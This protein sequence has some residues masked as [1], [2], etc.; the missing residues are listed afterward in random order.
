M[1]M[2]IKMNSTSKMK[3][4]P[5]PSLHNL[6]CPCFLSILNACAAL[7]RA[8][9]GFNIIFYQPTHLAPGFI[10]ILNASCALMRVRVDNEVGFV[11]D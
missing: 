11:L 2:T 5:G 7:I 4:V 9:V 3:T 10:Y 1:K 8:R 6:S